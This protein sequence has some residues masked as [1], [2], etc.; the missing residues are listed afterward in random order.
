MVSRR[1]WTGRTPQDRNLF[2]T[3][4]AV[5]E[6]PG[7]GASHLNAVSPEVFSRAGELGEN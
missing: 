7:S 3:I 2:P 4:P 6:I 1:F 5:P